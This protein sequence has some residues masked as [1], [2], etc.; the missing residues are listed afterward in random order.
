[1]KKLLLL[2]LL[3][4]GFTAFA[5]TVTYSK[6]YSGDKLYGDDGSE[7]RINYSNKLVCE[8]GDLTRAVSYSKSTSG[9]GYFY[10]DDGSECRMNYSDKLECTRKEKVSNTYKTDPNR[11]RVSVD[12]SYNAGANFFQSLVS[13]FDSSSSSSTTQNNNSQKTRLF[14]FGTTARLNPNTFSLSTSNGF[15]CTSP[16]NN[17]SYCYKGNRTISF[18]ICGETSNTQTFCVSDGSK[19]TLN[20]SSTNRAVTTSFGSTCSA[21]FLNN[22]Q[23]FTCR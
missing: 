20:Y 7:C 14:D 1:M 21:S 17:K 22:V 9:L 8:G 3:S 18:T 13:L 19:Y 15:S 6:S 11:G 4:L 12:A 23:I 16:K 10:G 5:G 2:L